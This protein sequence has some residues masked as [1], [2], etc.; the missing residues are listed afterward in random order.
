MVDHCRRVITYTLLL[1]ERL[2]VAMAMMEQLALGA[3][4]HDV[5]KLALPDDVLYKKAD[6][7]TPVERE[8]FETH[9]IHSYRM[10]A[11]PLSDFPV[12]LNVVRHHHER[13]DGKG[14]PDGLAGN[15][16]PLE[17]RLVAVANQFDRMM[18]GASREKRSVWEAR[19]DISLTVGT[20]LCPRCTDAF[21]TIAPEILEA[22]SHGELDRSGFVGPLMRGLRRGVAG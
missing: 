1:A 5:G 7:Y 19:R 22:V 16:I 9:P 3:A 2:P 8:I 12:A 10:L 20:R 13:Y 6:R 14:Y 11:S 18:S 15:H 4:F 21:L 17:A